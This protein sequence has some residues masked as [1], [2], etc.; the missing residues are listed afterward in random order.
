[1][2][3]WVQKNKFYKMSSTL[4]QKSTSLFLDHRI[5]VRRHEEVA[6]NVQQQKKLSCDIFICLGHTPYPS[7][8]L[9]YRHSLSLLRLFP[10]QF[11][12]VSKRS[13]L[14]SS[15]YPDKYKLFFALDIVCRCEYMCG[16]ERA[17]IS[18]WLVVPLTW[19]PIS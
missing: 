11:P 17:V 15:F 14:S 16:E 6:A 13:F 1:M 19:N 18:V 8:I 5:S 4:D 10:L 2:A 9:F 12:F 3:G 7:L